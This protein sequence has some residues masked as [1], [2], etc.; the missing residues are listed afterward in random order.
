MRAMKDIHII[1]GTVMGT[2][3]KTAKAIAASLGGLGYSLRIN[4]TFQ[5]TEDLANQDDILLLITSNTGMGD[6]PENIRP[7]YQHLTNDY[8]KL[9]GHFYGLV[10]LGDSSYPNFAQAG[11]T[12]DAAMADLGARR[13]GEPLI[14][15]ALIHDDPE[16]EG[17]QW[18]LQWASKLNTLAS[19]S[20]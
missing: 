14:I 6:L 1:V 13:I 15:D 8:P 2:A 9:A 5:A 4:A 19:N 17:T 20:P 10:V 7:L 16:A 3:L 12:L 18:A 11:E